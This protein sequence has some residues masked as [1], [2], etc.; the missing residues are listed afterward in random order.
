MCV[1]GEPAGPQ[2]SDYSKL[3]S[4]AGMP[5]SESENVFTAGG[6][7]GESSLGLDPDCKEQQQQEQLQEL[8]QGNG[9]VVFGAFVAGSLVGIV[10]CAPFFVVLLFGAGAAALTNSDSKVGRFS[11]KVGKFS[12]SVLLSA[13]KKARQFNKTHQ[14]TSRASEAAKQTVARAKTEAQKRGLGERMKARASAVWASIDEEEIFVDAGTAAAPVTD[15][16]QLPFG[17]ESNA[18]EGKGAPKEFHA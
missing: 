11:R 13:F 3:S 8:E 18:R 12:S 9:F 1:A 14:V 16:A 4:A 2:S 5:N 7:G 10:I 6:G 17:G 15:G